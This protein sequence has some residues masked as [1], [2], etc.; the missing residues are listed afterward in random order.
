VHNANEVEGSRIPSR[1]RSRY[2]FLESA[3][4]CSF[5]RASFSTILVLTMLSSPLMAA[6]NL[7]IWPNVSFA[8]QLTDN[9]SQQTTSGSS[10]DA[11]SIVN[12]GGSATVN[13]NDRNF[14][15]DLSTQAQVYAR[16]SSLDQGPQDNQYVGLRDYERLSEVTGLSINDT[17]LN[18]QST[19]GQGLIGP[20][21]ASP[22]L[23]Q[24]FLQNNYL[25]NTFNLQL[26]RQLSERASTSFSVHQN[27][28]SSSGS[29]AS[30]S[31]GQTSESFQQGGDLA[32]YYALYPQLSVG[33]DFQFND[34]RFSN[35]PH[36]DSLQPSIDVTWN[37]SE[38][39]V[40]S[41]QIGPL[42]ISSPTGTSVGVGYTLT[43][44][45]TGER[46]L[47]KL[48]S[49]R[50]PSISAGLSGA[51][52]SQYQGASAQYQMS[53]RTSAYI[54]TSFDQF[55]QTSSNSY[56]IIYGVGI[57]HQLSQSI[58]L[59]GQFTRYQTNSPSIT[60]N[61]TDTLTLG[62]KFTPGPW[63]WTF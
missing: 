27:Y 15:L 16:N 20:S 18:G 39:L 48:Y 46:W 63:I 4:R 55:S 19:F 14:E 29:Q 57:S 42:I 11:I 40:T 38:H 1:Q 47:L 36:S 44:I 43:T 61:G 21:G 34:F 53:R 56:V 59:F 8:E 51:S 30:E 10:S 49:S 13:S 17:F 62:I 50:T 37:P 26:N 24:A 22:L 33:P 28:F 41:A 23:S 31:S 52:V 32:G 9:L 3:K 7:E 58:S 35:Q 54:N 25:A 6:D 60:G 2:R 5:L 12:M 45:Y